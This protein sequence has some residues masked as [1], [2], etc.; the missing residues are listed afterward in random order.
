MLTTNQL[1]LVAETR[2]VHECVRLGLGVSRPLD[3]ERYDL[4]LDL[5]PQLLRAQCKWARRHGDVMIVRCRRCRR[6]R[7]GA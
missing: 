3:D 2:I 1:G 5:R 6:G 4:I 7:E